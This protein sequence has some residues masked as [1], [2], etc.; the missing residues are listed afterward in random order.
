MRADARAPAVLADAPLAVM[1]ADARAP[2]VLAVAPLAIMLADAR[3]P[4]VLA[5]APL[6]VMR[7]DARAPAVLAPAP[8]AVMV[9]DARAP[10]VLA[11][12]PLTVMLT[13][14]M[15]MA[16]WKQHVFGLVSSAA[17][18]H[19]PAH[20]VQ[21]DQQVH[22]SSSLQRWEQHC[23]VPLGNVSLSEI[24]RESEPEDLSW[25]CHVNS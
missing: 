14:G 7:A 6:A 9:A 21:L 10:A 8:D 4:A 17:H 25:S 5:V 18:T 15:A 19:T 13:V 23:S 12:A 20:Q 1:R 16:R 22:P 11:V 24:P 2:A 3:A